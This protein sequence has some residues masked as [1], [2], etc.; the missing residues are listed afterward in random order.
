MLLILGSGPSSYANGEKYLSRRA[1]LHAYRTCKFHVLQ[2][3]Q[4]NL[5]QGWP[6]ISGKVQTLSDQS[7]VG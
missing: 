1:H 6:Y 7:T 4:S 5:A 3:G 2:F